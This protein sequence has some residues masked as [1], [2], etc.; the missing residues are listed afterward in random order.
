DPAATDSA[1][2]VAPA[3]DLEIESNASRQRVTYFVD[4][5][6]GRLHDAFERA[7][8]RQ[9]AYA[10]VIGDRLAAAGLPRDLTYLAFIE[11]Y[12]DPDA[13]SKAAAVGMWQFMAGTARGVGLR[14]DW[15]VD[16]RRDPVRSTEGAVRLLSSLHDEFGSHFLAAAAYDGGEGRVSRGLARFAER[17][18][19]VEGED[20]YFALS[21]TRYLRPET[22]DYVPKIIAAALVAKQPDR[23]GLHVDSLP[24]FAF[25]SVLVPG[26]TPL[27]AVASATPTATD[28]IRALNPH[29]L[30]GMVP[31]GDSMWV[32]VPVS[33]AAGFSDRF[34]AL[35][36]AVLV[37]WTAVKSKKGESMVSIARRHKMTS[38]Q[39]GWFNPK[40]ARLKSG[41]LVSGQTILVPTAA[42][43]AA[44]RDVPNPSIER[45]PRRARSR[46]PARPAATT[47]AKTPT[48]TPSK[49]TPKS[50]SKATGSAGKPPAKRP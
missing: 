14:V 37:P 44:A 2:S 6:S 1:A 8:G 15:W 42:V 20:R 28:S 12:Y 46:P 18:E 38:K 7:L 47:P 11:S 13:Y 30:R 33:S 50:P 39:L 41:N 5:F 32:R 23:Y 16:E 3:W 43:L 49:T 10:G 34:A 36:S 24:A 4:V 40:V 26:G 45:Y 35:D 25:D 19:G 31:P 48:K 9:T 21:D 22:R 27:A 17:L 29:I